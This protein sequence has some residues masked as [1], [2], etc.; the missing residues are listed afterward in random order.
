MKKSSLVA[1]C[2]ALPLTGLAVPGIAAQPHCSGAPG[3]DVPVVPSPRAIEARIEQMFA[4]QEAIFRQMAALMSVPLPDAR[5]L[6]E[7]GFSPSFHRDGSAGSAEDHA[8]AGPHQPRLI[9][10]EY[11]PPSPWG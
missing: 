1:A 5:Q 7:A 3:Y 8:V 4:R 9:E 11:R 6:V 2:L 10:A